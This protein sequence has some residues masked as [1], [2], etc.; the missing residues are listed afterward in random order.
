M[1]LAEAPAG[2]ILRSA[3]RKPPALDW[4]ARVLLAYEGGWF[5]GDFDESLRDGLRAHCQQVDVVHGRQPLPPGYDLVL[6]YGPF[7]LDSGTLLPMA[8]RLAALPRAQRP[9][10]AWWLTEGVPDPRL[11]GWLANWLAGLRLA[12]DRRLALAPGQRRAGWRNVLASGHRLRILGQ[13]R[14]AQARGVLSVL[15]V[16]SA[17]R[18]GYLRQRGLRTIV[19]PLG[20]HRAYGADL[21]LPRDIQVAFLGNTDAPRRKRLLPGLLAQLAERG[22]RVQME[23]NLYGEARNEYLNRSQ[24]LLNVLREPQDFVGQRFLL[25]AANK[26]LVVSEPF[27]DS[28]PFIPGEHLAVAPP[29][30]L[31]ETVAG[32]LADEA[33]RAQLAERAHRFVTQELTVVQMAGRI[34]HQLRQDHAQA[35]AT[36]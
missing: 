34:L 3:E 21:G 32:Y 18:A 20:Y 17:S 31:A 23:N 12:A 30:E 4:P 35:G 13:L 36:A 27:N 5:G 15:A 1:P 9:A 16:T 11:P 6:G 24:I 33:A 10:F 14:W 8:Q 19:V 22:I 29:A 28:E 26:A 25:A 2:I 7:S